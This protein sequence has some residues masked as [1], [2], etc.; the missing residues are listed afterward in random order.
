MSWISDSLI[1]E[2]CH[3]CINI[4]LNVEIIDGSLYD[5]VYKPLA[6]AEIIYVTINRSD[7]LVIH[8][9]REFGTSMIE[10]SDMSLNK[11]LSKESLFQ[12]L[13]C[14]PKAKDRAATVPYDMI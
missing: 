4:V 1:A 11:V 7:E 8:H 9:M 3:A 5:T 2:N 13:N 14:P 12:S 6:E 10:N